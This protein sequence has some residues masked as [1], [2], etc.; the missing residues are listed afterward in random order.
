MTLEN[1]KVT[2]L[3]RIKIPKISMDLSLENEL[4]Y[5]SA[6]IMAANTDEFQRALHYQGPNTHHLILK[7]NDWLNKTI[8]K[9]QEQNASFSL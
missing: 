5:Q 2:H 1:Y 8:L 4:N 3:L 6:H 7:L 9:K